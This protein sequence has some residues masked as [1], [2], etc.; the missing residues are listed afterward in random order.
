MNEERRKKLEWAVQNIIAPIVFEEAWEVGETHGVITITKVKISSDL[1]YLD[2]FVSCFVEPETL[3]HD[4]AKFW[5]A[6]QRRLN[7]SL[8][9]Y[10]LPRV[11]FRYDESWEVWMWV[12]QLIRSIEKEIQ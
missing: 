5:N 12:E 10:K 8:D 1:S 2:V 4:I 9:I 6:I 11:R 3:A 7:K